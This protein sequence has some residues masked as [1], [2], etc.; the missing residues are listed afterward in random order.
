[1][2]TLEV[3]ETTKPTPLARQ[4]EDFLA[5]ARARGKSPKTVE[6]YAWPLRRLLLPYAAEAGIEDAGGITQ[7]LMDQLS[8]E[9]LDPEREK[10]L[11]RASA[12]SYLRQINV[13][14]GWVREQGDG[15]QAKAHVP[16][17]DKKVRL[18]LSRDEIQLLEDAA[19]AERDRLIVRVLADSGVRLG[20]LLG[21]RCADLIDSPAGWSLKVEGK[22]RRQRLIPIAPALAKRL[23]RYI[24]HTRPKAARTDRLFIGLRRSRETGEYEA[25]SPRSVQ[26]LLHAL[27]DGAKVDPSRCHPHA[28]RHSAATWLL[29]RRVDPLRVA[30]YLGHR[31]LSMLWSAYGHLGSEDIR[32]DLMLAIRTDD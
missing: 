8:T 10:P 31:D 12:A 17:L 15:S 22:G 6:I 2:A 20:E 7:A 29:R 27:A 21:L 25:L 5:S 14:L 4:V 9:L 3:V 32:D 26:N 24:E 13:F 18:V 1:M 16:G 30:M 28:F 23:R 19:Q 11:S